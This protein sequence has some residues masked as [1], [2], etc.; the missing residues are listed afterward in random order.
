MKPPYTEDDVKHLYDV[1]GQ[2]LW[3]LQHLERAL[4][5][6]NTLKILQHK[7]DKEIKITQLMGQ[8]VLDG[9]RKQTLG[10][11]IGIAKR[12]KTIPQQILNRFDDFLTERNWLIHKC[13][14]DEYLSL[15]NVNAKEKLYARIKRFIDESIELQKEVAN[16]IE[17]SY[18]SSGKDLAC[19]YSL[20]EKTLKDAEK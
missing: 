6:F 5:I 8:K 13:V 12:E 7:I 19:A 4:T 14:I 11:L 15:R 3:Y 2:A 17:S 1:L 10:P 16:L 9:Q 18:V 20:A